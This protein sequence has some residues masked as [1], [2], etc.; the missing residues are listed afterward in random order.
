MPLHSAGLTVAVALAAGVL[1]QS[2]SRQL[3]LP[4]IAL[5]LATGAA[6]GPEVAGWIAPDS[7][8]D[9]LFAL[10][11][12]GVAIVLFEGGLNLE[13]SRLRR[14][15]AVIRKL[16]TVGALAT[17]VGATGVAWLVLDWGWRL[18]LLFGSLV[19]VTG[20][21]VVSPLL[22]D[23]RL[24]PRMRTILEA[25][26]VLID[27]IGALLA[28]FMLQVVAAPTV[29]TIAA[30]GFG[31][32]AS[33]AF[34]LA[35]GGVVGLVLIGALR[36]RFVVATGYEN[37]F[38]L[39]VVVLA[40]QLCDAVIAHSGLTAVTVAGVVVGNVETRVGRDLRE[41]KDRL[42]VMLV[43]LLFVLL[44]A[45][46]ALDDVRALGGGGLV[47]LG[48]LVLVIR[49]VSV[50]VATRGVSLT[51][52]ERGFI[53]WIAPRGIIAAAIAS[54]TAATLDAE[55]IAGG[56]ALRALV[57][58][59]IAGTVVL[60]GATAR[61]MA[62][63]LG[64]LLSRRDRVAILGA[65][66]LG[67][68]LATE[69]RR[70]EVTVVFLET[71]PKRS[72]TAEEAGFAVVFGDPLEE[73]TMLRAQ[74]ALVG[75]AV[76]TTFNEHLNNVFVRQALELF[77]VPSGYVAMDAL[78]GEGPAAYMAPG[79]A[80]VLFDGPHDGERWDVRWRHGDMQVKWLVYGTRPTPAFP[81]GDPRP[82]A[83]VARGASP[84]ERYV[85]LTVS[86]G[87]QVSPMRMGFSPRPG[88]VA[89]VAFYVAERA[90]ALEVLAGLGWALADEHPA[91][92]GGQS[93][94]KAET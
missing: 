6:L 63:S 94:V 56:G 53:A 55:G 3:R 39:A 79:A 23:M 89:A 28:A 32:A 44:A 41:F 7:L 66:G 18:S 34:G 83:P 47:V 74:P 90:Q 8:G 67:L 75:T 70:A 78:I 71:D 62:W 80:D 86:R 65:T 48:A 51:M 52:R 33:I 9:G 21:T 87:K 82:A 43:G 14:Q 29:G 69:L 37:I 11:D 45:D 24:H 36:Y 92:A 17:L 12:F 5:L 93:D 40:F 26:G 19:V 81:D 64:L 46:V 20:P 16:I 50:W 49:P 25:E 35:A 73:R 30:Q 77:D 22:R 60:A 68:A 59:T 2:L 85:M 27:P 72:R 38:T 15:E 84:Q 88:D 61:G 76:G 57:F 1:A 10:V 54:I 4:G 31:V 42:T 91:A 58:L 13:W